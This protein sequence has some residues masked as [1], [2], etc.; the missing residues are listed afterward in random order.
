MVVGVEPVV[1][2]SRPAPHGRR[3]RPCSSDVRPDLQDFSVIAARLEVG[4][5]PLVALMERHG[6]A[7]R[8]TSHE[9][10]PGVLV[11]RQRAGDHGGATG[12]HQLGGSAS[13]SATFAGSSPSAASPSSSGAIS[14][15]SIPTRSRPG[16]TAAAA[17]RRATG[18]ASTP[19]P[20]ARGY[21]LTWTAILRSSAIRANAWPTLRLVPN[22]SWWPCMR[23]AAS[24]SAINKPPAL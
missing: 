6:D 13:R 20:H 14:C 15:A 22:H 23:P 9:P 3:P 4:Q 5:T 18:E 12:R 8:R 17:R 21:S 24:V 7:R 1:D 11:D 2:A 19:R 16:S 10:A